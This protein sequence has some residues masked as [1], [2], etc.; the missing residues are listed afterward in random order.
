MRFFDMGQRL[1]MGDWEANSYSYDPQPYIWL[2]PDPG[3]SSD[4][5]REL[6][7]IDASGVAGLESSVLV[8]TSSFLTTYRQVNKTVGNSFPL[9]VSVNGT[10]YNFS[11]PEWVD[12]GLKL[13]QGTLIGS[14]IDISV[15]RTEAFS[16]PKLTQDFSTNPSSSKCTLLP[17]PLAPAVTFT[18][19]TRDTYFLMP[20]LSLSE[21]ESI[22]L[23]APGHDRRI[24]QN[25][26]Y[27]I[28]PRNFLNPNYATGSSFSDLPWAEALGYHTGLAGART[29]TVEFSGPPG[30]G[31]FRGTISPG[32]SFPITDG[33]NNPTI[34]FIPGAIFSGNLMGV[35]KQG[36]RFY[37][38][39]KL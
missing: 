10:P 15:N 6:T 3:G 7:P 39:W 5:F 27:R 35:V 34:A 17:S 26:F 13:S 2:S 22:I 11:S 37:Y 4:E 23:I 33:S 18:P 29:F 19:T 8:P 20:N 9:Q 32:G 38:F 16:T 1:V 28:V 24:I 12:S 21:G 25:Y 36:V 30:V 31:P 14:F